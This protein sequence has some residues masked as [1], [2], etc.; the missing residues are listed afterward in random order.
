LRRRGLYAGKM[1]DASETTPA[2]RRDDTCDETRSGK[3][4]ADRWLPRKGVQKEEPAAVERSTGGAQPWERHWT[5]VA[6]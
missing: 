3:E 2:A 4:E 6:M 1:S 5:I